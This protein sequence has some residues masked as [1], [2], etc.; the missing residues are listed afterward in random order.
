MSIDRKI[1]VARSTDD[2]TRSSRVSA[3]SA[4]ALGTAPPEANV[5]FRVIRHSVEKLGG[6]VVDLGAALHMDDPKTIALYDRVTAMVA[7]IEIAFDAL[8]SHHN[9]P[10]KAPK[11]FRKF[12]QRSPTS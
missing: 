11:P 8:A 4:S 1:Q 3:L 2:D 6:Q 9:C 7:R 5:K 12:E 10:W